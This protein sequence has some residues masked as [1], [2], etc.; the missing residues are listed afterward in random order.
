MLLGLRDVE[1]LAKA[2]DL[3]EALY[4]GDAL[5]DRAVHMVKEIF[6]GGTLARPKSDPC[7]TIRENGKD[8]LPSPVPPPQLGFGYSPTWGHEGYTG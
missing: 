4:P 1:S 3:Y 6:A 8:T 2:E 7:L 5:T